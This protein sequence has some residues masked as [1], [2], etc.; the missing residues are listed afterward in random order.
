MKTSFTPII[1][2]I[3]LTAIAV[4]TFA[5][6]FALDTDVSAQE[7][8]R[9]GGANPTQK[10]ESSKDDKSKDDA[11][12]D[13]SDKKAEEAKEVLAI[14]GA[15][16]HTVTNGVVRQGTI[17]I[18]EGKITDVGIDL[19]IPKNATVIDATGKVISPGFVAISMSGIALRSAPSGKDK[20]EDGLDPFDQNMKYALGVGITT[21]CVELSTGGGGFRRRRDPATG[22]EL[23]PVMNDERLLNVGEPEDIFPGLEEPKETLLTEQ[24]IDYGDLNTAL[25]PC[26]GLP[27]LPT[28]P[29]E[30]SRPT[31][32]QPR[33]MAAIKLAY[34]NVGS[35]LSKDEV[36]YNPTPGGLNGALNR[37]NWRVEMRKAQAQ[38]KAEAEEA[39]KTKP[40]SKSASD[41]KSNDSS[42]SKPSSSS[43]S[44]NKS[45][46][47]SKTP[48]ANPELVKL[49][50]GELTMRVRSDSYDEISDLTDLAQEFGYKLVIEGGTEA[51]ALSEKLSEA[52]VEMIYTPRRRREPVKGRE[53][54]SGSHFESP[55]IF[56]KAGIPFAT[57]ALSGS[58]SMMGLAGRD[59]TSLP[60]EAAFAI[61]G[62]ASEKAALESLTIT[63]ARMMGLEDR[64]GSI[65]VGKDADL[66]ILNG[67]PL[68]YKTYVEQAIVAG[69]VAYDRSEDKVFP[70]YERED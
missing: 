52:G 60:L 44:N 28:E 63:P 70:V 32:N 56:E 31:T 4:G 13:K 64:I 42:T 65:E 50:K 26:C 11:K 39:S 36:F 10:P 66:L 69:K 14:K 19:E 46:T 8:R 58:I 53:N 35:M 47:A 5:S 62:G 59:L 68:D 7:R 2:S 45:S 15:D 12:D 49:L 51:W 1:R 17:L 38:I 24:M 55:M 67:T 30:P 43:S 18:S 48:K 40:D 20:I 41:S 9:R 61:R 29:I 25:C 3:F 37:H 23:Q 22:E 21:G 54:N 6:L 57:S 34:G 33:K 16:I 27:V